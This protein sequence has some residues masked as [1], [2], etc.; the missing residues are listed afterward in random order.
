[1]LHRD[2]GQNLSMKERLVVSQDGPRFHGWPVI[3]KGLTDASDS[4]SDAKSV[5]ESLVWNIWWWGRWL[6]F[7]FSPWAFFLPFFH[8]SFLIFW[9]W[10]C[11]QSSFP[12]LFLLFEYFSLWRR[13]CIFCFSYNLLRRL[14]RRVSSFTTFFQPC[15]IIWVHH[16]EN[17]VWLM[18]IFLF[19]IIMLIIL[20][21]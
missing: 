14:F 21:Q 9:A 1:M 18:L 10:G 15:L 13:F 12:W 4:A 6:C 8:L 11:T 16:R 3:V 19:E 17:K 7:P 20:W 5:V 2:N